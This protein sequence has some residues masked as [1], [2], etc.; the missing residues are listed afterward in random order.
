MRQVYVRS[1]S[2]IYEI[3]YPSKQEATMSIS[4]RFV[5]GLQLKVKLLTCA[6][7]MNLVLRILGT[8]IG[9]RQRKRQG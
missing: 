5:V 8:L 1:T 9:L 3:Y 6:E 7:I 4:A 2:R